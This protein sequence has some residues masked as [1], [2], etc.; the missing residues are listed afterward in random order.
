MNK[1]TIKIS[2]VLPRLLKELNMSAKQLSKAAHI[3]PS[4]ISTWC[5]PKSKPKNIQDVAAAADVLGVSLN[6]LLFGEADTATD[7]NNLAGE[8]LLNGIYR[9]KLERI[10]L[11]GKK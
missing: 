11:N 6:M 9:I 3:S 10:N 1:K 8:T 4:T 2:E 5:L 7:L